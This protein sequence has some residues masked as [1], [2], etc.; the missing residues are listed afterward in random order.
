M[1]RAWWV[2]PGLLVAVGLI[3]IG[4]GLGYLGSGSFMDYDIRW[5]WIGLAL[6]AL[7]LVAGFVAS[8][9]ARS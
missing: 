1:N 2:G 3:F 8:R 4:Q 7:G 6:A 5:A 9:R